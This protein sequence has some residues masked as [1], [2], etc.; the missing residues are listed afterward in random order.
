MDFYFKK[1]YYH[2]TENLIYFFYQFYFSQSD[3]ERK[4]KKKRASC[5]YQTEDRARERGI[6]RANATREQKRER[7]R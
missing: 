1:L 7:E 2:I 4:E 6:D 3:L 5:K